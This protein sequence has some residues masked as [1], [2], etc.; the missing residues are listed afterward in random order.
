MRLLIALLVA[1][2]ALAQ[3]YDVR[4]SDSVFDAQAL[5]AR[6]SGQVLTFY[7]DGQSEYY[8][9][10]RYT[11]TYAGDGGTAYGYWRITEDG[12]VCVEFVNGFARCDLYVMNGTRLLLLDGGGARFP[13]RP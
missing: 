7:D 4:P 1:T 6:L 10:G 11:Y 2:P 3:G 13:V 8:E 12:A 5:D 9:D